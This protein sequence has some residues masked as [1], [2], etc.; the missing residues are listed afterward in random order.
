[1]TKANLVDVIYECVGSSK[2]DACAVVESVFDI[3]RGALCKGDKVKISGFG[4]F[5]VNE[6]SARRGRNPQTG[7]PITIDSRRVLSF[8]PSQVLKDRINNGAS[9][10]P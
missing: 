2:R 10:R 5:S 4:T 6:K 7:A 9:P 3:I 1:M 8:K